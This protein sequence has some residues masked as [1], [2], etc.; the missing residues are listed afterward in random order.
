VVRL[1]LWVAQGKMI[2]LK[3]L[4]SMQKQLMVW[5]DRKTHA[6]V[7]I[8]IGLYLILFLPVWKPAL[9]GFLFAAA[10][11][12]LVNR[13]RIRL[14]TKRS[15]VAGLMVT[16]GIILFVGFVV[17]VGLQIYSQLFDLFQNKEQMGG[18]GEKIHGLRNDI[19]A[20]V[21]SKP[22]LSSFNIAQK[23]D[24]A[25]TGITSSVA[26]VLM[27]LAQ[28]FVKAAPDI[29]LNLLIFIVAF[30]AFLSIQPRMW[31]RIS[32]ALRLGGRGKEHFQRFEKICT[33]A[34]GSVILTALL[35][36]VLVVI[37][38]TLAGYQLQVLIFS[39][40]FFL[41]MIPVVGAGSVP[42]FLTLVSFLQGDTT[43]GIIMAVFS[44]IVGVSDNI[45]RAWLFSRAAKSNPAISLITLIGG[46][47]LFGFPGLFI[48]PVV[49]QL[50]MTYAFSDE[51]E[52]A[53]GEIAA[54]EEP[55]SPDVLVEPS[56]RQTSTS[57]R[58]DS[59]RPQPT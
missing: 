20:W 11:A 15:R 50:V 54:D 55:V 51:G 7:Y 33:L 24:R 16:V 57:K 3:E 18:L 27:Y 6:A 47:A 59:L 13:L 28:N 26:G 29:V 25:V 12:P 53:P 8:L 2:F 10:C 4:V 42:I 22:Y 14:N 35:Q 37:G 58:Q 36:S 41:A 1:P 49:E 45:L 44:V 19:V 48:A 5:S 31:T 43:G 21:S 17:V 23:I 34:L 52:P 32:Q 40:S 30:G 39:V 56:S 46:I 38:A 9:L